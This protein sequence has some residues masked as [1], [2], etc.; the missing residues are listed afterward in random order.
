LRSSFK[1]AAQS[2]YNR[3][4]NAAQSQSN[5]AG[6][7]SAYS[8]QMYSEDSVK[9]SE[10]AERKKGKEAHTHKHTHKQHFNQPHSP[11]VAFKTPLL[12]IRVLL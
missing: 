1:I 12:Q 3:F 11:V 4:V 7:E 10:N 8:A 5:Y 2:L 9:S 6:D